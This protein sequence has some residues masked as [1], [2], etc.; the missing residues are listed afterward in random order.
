MYAI[1]RRRWIVDLAR[2]AGRV[3]VQQ[4]CDE[5]AVAPETVRRD[6]N[7]LERQG[8]LR[9]VH[10]GA[11]PVEGLGFEG[12]LTARSSARAAEKDRIA[13]AA[14]AVVGGADSVFIDEGSTVAALAERLHPDRPLTVVTSALA[15]A[16]R[17]ASRPRLQVL[18]LGG[19][20]RPHALGC[21]DHWA[22]RMLEDLVLDVAVLG[23]NGVSAQHGLTCP[24]PHVAA[25]KAAAVR[26][27]RRRI[28][29]A[30]HTKFGV[31]SFCRF[32]TVKELDTVVTDRT[33]SNDHL[34]AVQDAGVEVVSA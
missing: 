14:L 20:V 7:E 21:V 26:A 11:V 33:S 31:D 29:L 23:T 10:G 32:A 3:E 12:E 16:S 18:Q 4:V 15:V 22:V 25:V 1:E 34:K 6:L 30:D 24:D 28:L 13:D 2:R 17:I 5:L 8:Q 9:R 19:R 27:G